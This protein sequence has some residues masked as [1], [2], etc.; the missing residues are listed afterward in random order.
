VRLTRQLLVRSRE[1][2]CGNEVGSPAT[3]SARQMMQV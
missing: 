1:G 3:N 2:S